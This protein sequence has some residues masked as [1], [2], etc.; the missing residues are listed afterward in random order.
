M[1]LK[2]TPL[3]G[4]LRRMVT[5]WKV[6]EKIFG[7][8]I[9]NLMTAFLIFLF[10]VLFKD[11]LYNYFAPRS[12][13]GDWPIHC[14]VEPHVN[15]KGTAVVA[16]L[17][18]VNLTG[19]KY[20]ATDLNRLAKESSPEQGKPLQPEILISMRDEVDLK[21][22]E[23]KPDDE[24]N[25]EKG[26]VSVRWIDDGR[27][28][29]MVERIEAFSMLRVV[30]TTKQERIITSRGDFESLPFTVQNARSR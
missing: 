25:S 3:F 5:E 11:P 17:F 2:L 23:F 29:M 30:I 15:T 10:V 8:V 21:S 22:L 28:A 13:V 9:V 24:F 20:F 12:S 7:P 18:I 27:W 14:I 6:G 26:G 19:K 1:T 16:D 4:R